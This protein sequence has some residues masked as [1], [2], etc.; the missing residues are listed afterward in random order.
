VI[1][2]VV[3]GAV[4]L[5]AFAGWRRGFIMPLI[6]VGTALVGLYALYAGPGASVV[7]SGTA[8]IGLGVLVVG[9]AASL[10]ARIGSMLA[11]LITRVSVLRAADHT[12][13]VPLGAATALVSV[14]VALVAVVSFDNLIAPLHG[15][16]TVD[17]AA[18]AAMHAAIAANPQFG[19]MLDPGTLDAMAAQV[20]K[21]A[22]PADQIATF[23]AT[24]GFYET[25]VRPAL[26][27]SASAPVILAVGERAPF[28]GRHVEFPAK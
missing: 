21:S 16:A 4:A 12:L 28:I 11:S 13:G 7:P 1:D 3:L 20:A 24:L 6:A 25:T 2:L 17:Q 9:V 26:L 22:I 14:Y 23:D 15:K 19:V 27:T 10:I 8:G 5:G 18:V